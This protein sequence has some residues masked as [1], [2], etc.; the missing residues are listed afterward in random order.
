MNY[1]FEDDIILDRNISEIDIKI[2]DN[3]YEIN[4]NKIIKNTNFVISY[5]GID[6]DSNNKIIIDK[7]NTNI[8]LLSRKLSNN[9]I[10]IQH[11]NIINLIDIV[12]EKNITYI[13]KPYYEKTLISQ[14]E[15]YNNNNK[16]IYNYFKQI[17]DGIKYLNDKNILIETIFIDNIFIIDNNIIISPYFFDYD[18]KLNKKNILYGS[19]LYNPPEIFQKN[20]PE[21]E[22]I[23]VWNIGMIFFQLIFNT[24]PFDKYKEYDDINNNDIQN[25]YH[26]DNNID[27]ELIDIIFNMIN[28]DKKN[29]INF[30]NIIIFF[31]NYDKIKN[32]KNNDDIFIFDDS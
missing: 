10:N 29:R 13:I 12:I 8:L 25:I 24:N 23:L 19:P 15:Y 6:I 28:I 4:L 18:T 30:Q 5:E 22:N 26:I 32:K 11:K 16:F 27:T 31:D 14:Y 20:I 1:F 21:R 3:K 7:Y 17:I 2:L 9:I